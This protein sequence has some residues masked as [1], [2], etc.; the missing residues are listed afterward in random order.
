MNALQIIEAEDPKR[1]L[2]S[3]TQSEY[4]RFNMDMSKPRIWPSN[5]YYINLAAP[6]E[7]WSEG[8]FCPI[9]IRHDGSGEAMD[10]MYGLSQDVSAAVGNIGGQG[11]EDAYVAGMDQYEAPLWAAIEKGITSGT[12]DGVVGPRKWR[13]VWSPVWSPDRPNLN[14]GHV[15]P[16]EANRKYGEPLGR[17][18]ALEVAKL[19]LADE[20]PKAVI[21]D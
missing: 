11:A 17:D 19:V 10:G 18:E 21:N 14:L 13:I 4:P 3:I 1:V 7:E 2:R 20:D 15:V 16:V 12:L 9:L 6:E 8:E 5:N